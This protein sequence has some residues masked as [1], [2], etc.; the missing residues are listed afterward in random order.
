MKT[1]TM[2][3]LLCMTAAS[4]GQDLKLDIR[5]AY[6][7]TVTTPPGE[8][9][10]QMGY[11]T[12]GL[13]K[14]QLVRLEFAIT[15]FSKDTAVFATVQNPCRDNAF[16]VKDLIT[17]QVYDKCGTLLHSHKDNINVRDDQRYTY[18]QEPTAG[19]NISNVPLYHSRLF[20]NI[21]QEAGIQG[22]SPGFWHHTNAFPSGYQLGFATSN[23]PAVADSYYVKTFL[24][25]GNLNQ[26]ANCNT[27]TAT[28]WY[29]IDAAG[30]GFAK[31]SA[32]SPCGTFGNRES[33]PCTDFTPI[34]N[35]SKSG[36]EFSWNGSNCT[37]KTVTVKIV[38]GNQV[39]YSESYSVKGNSWKHEGAVSKK[40]LQ[41]LW[42]GGSAYVIEVSDGQ[43]TLKT[44]KFNY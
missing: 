42:G 21:E 1:M 17:I 37:D 4:Y 29:F 18:W 16:E 6:L 10:E 30:S 12:T 40:N 32:P 35:L 33:E 14:T 2:L 19:C 34:S 11:D 24:N 31:V 44:E 3:L 25:I 27:D 43:T 20:S 26:G 36:N 41:I 13:P 23:L 15:N 22:L 8:C 9:A 39:K 7:W 5:N 28:Q 38:R